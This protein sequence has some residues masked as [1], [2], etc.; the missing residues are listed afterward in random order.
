MERCVEVCW[1]FHPFLVGGNI[2]SWTM[3]LGW[4]NLETLL[5]MIA[6]VKVLNRGGR[7]SSS[8]CC[9]KKPISAGIHFL[10]CPKCMGKMGRVTDSGHSPKKVSTHNPAENIIS[11]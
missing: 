8:D 10:L 6:G 2:A 4:E 7:R 11:Q 3:A 9:L 1:L 5:I